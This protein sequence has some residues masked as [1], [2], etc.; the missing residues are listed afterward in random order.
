MILKGPYMKQA[1]LEQRYKCYG[2]FYSIIL[3]KY[4]F[5][6]RS[7]L[8]IINKTGVSH[9]TVDLLK[10]TPDL[11]VI[12]MNPGASKPEVDQKIEIQ[13]DSIPYMEITLTPTIPDRTQFQIMRVME[14]KNWTHSRILNLSDLRDP[15]SGS[16]YQYFGKLD[17]CKQ[18][19]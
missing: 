15:D 9:Q 6:C 1:M 13:M 4:K 3:G 10:R 5:P 16:F 17:S 7:V 2:H 8:E 19:C 18:I 12:M 11:V 14:A